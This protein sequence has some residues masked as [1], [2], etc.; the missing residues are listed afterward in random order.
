[1]ASPSFLGS[2]LANMSPAFLAL[3]RWAKVARGFLS[4]AG[5]VAMV[6]HGHAAGDSRRAPPGGPDAALPRAMDDVGRWRRFADDLGGKFHMQQT[7]PMEALMEQLKQRDGAKVRLR[8]A[9]PRKK[10]L[11]PEEVYDRCSASVVAMGSIY[12]C[13]RCPHWHTGGTGTGWV[14]GDRGEIVSNYHVLAAAK[15][16]NILAFGVMTL[17]GRCLPIREVLASD[18]A[19][20]VVIFR[21]D[22]VGLAPLPIA[23]REPV[24]RPVSVIAHPSGDLYTFTQGAVSRYALRATEPGTVPLEWMCVTA[25]FAVGSSGGPVLNRQGGV[26]GMVAR[27]QTI[28]ANPK[29]ESPATQM[30]VKMTIPSEAIR[31][32]LEPEARR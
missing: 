28:Q 19:R 13:L 5:V 12:K 21:V 2:V 4:L 9:P 1:L 20:D 32:L 22:G 3:S 6:L 26:V 31:S 18:P 23:P 14:L 7:L 15:E 25:D 10:A 8:L 17:D 30:V 24:G 27:T 11:E 29:G 16:T